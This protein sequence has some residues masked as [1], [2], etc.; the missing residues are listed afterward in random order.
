MN[1]GGGGGGGTETGD[2]ADTADTGTAACTTADLSLAVE[3]RD[4]NGQAD[5]S[6]TTADNLT[7]VAVATNTCAGTLSFSSA[8]C[9]VDG[10]TLQAASGTSTEVTDTCT[11]ADWTLESGEAAEPSYPA[12]YL[13]ADGYVL[14]ATLATGQSAE[15]VFTVLSY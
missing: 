3:V 11:A 6:F 2:T 12:G 13:V 9:L 1:T 7:F 14:T 8:G 10:W 4:A 5:T 15:V